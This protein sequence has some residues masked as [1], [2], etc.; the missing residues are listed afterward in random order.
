MGATFLGNVA[1]TCR[2]FNREAV[3]GP[4]LPQ[5]QAWFELQSAFWSPN[6]RGSRASMSQLKTCPTG[7]TF[8]GLAAA[9]VQRLAL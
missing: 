4:K 5:N 9:A 1:G 7:W 3:A 2:G 8:W 6:S